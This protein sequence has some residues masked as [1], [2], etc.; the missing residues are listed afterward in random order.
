ME[1]QL[2]TAK[3]LAEDL[4]W[5]VTSFVEQV[6]NVA[7]AIVVSADGLPLAVSE[8]FPAGRAEQLAAI[9]SGM[10]SLTLGASMV[11]DGGT[12][13]Q[14][15]VEMRRGILIVMAISDGST[16]AVLASND[17]DLEQVA[18]EMTLLA[19][20]TGRFLTPKARAESGLPRRDPRPAARSGAGHASSSRGA[21][22]LK[23]RRTT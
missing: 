7:H 17:A 11:F 19:E 5:L 1:S 8:G 6:K 3:R 21:P 16:L 15:A 13:I 12:V 10:A 20:R 9:T 23:R 4:G 14:S 22:T 2:T 18:Y